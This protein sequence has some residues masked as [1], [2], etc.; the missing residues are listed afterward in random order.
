MEN[1]QDYIARLRSHIAALE[2]E[3]AQYA[4]K[5]G[6]TDRTRELLKRPVE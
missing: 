3:L 1:T 5:Y 6:P 2:A 4:A